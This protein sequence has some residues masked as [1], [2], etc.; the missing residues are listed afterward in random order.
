MTPS[1][2]H[3]THASVPTGFRPGDSP[4]T[5]GPPGRSLAGRVLV[6]AA[7]VLGLAATGMVQAEADPFYVSLLRDGVDAASRDDLPAAEKSLRLACFGFLE[8]LDL[9]SQCLVRLALVESRAGDVEGFRQTFRRVLEI[10]DRFGAYTKAPLPAE[11]RRSFEEQAAA[12]VPEALLR[13][14]VAFRPLVDD[15]LLTQLD[16]L[17]VGQQREALETRI[18]ADPTDTRWRLRLARLEL[19]QDRPQAALAALTGIDDGDG[20]QEAGCLK[21][22][23]R[24]LA[25]DCTA[26]DQAAAC[27]RPQAQPKLAGRLVECYMNQNRWAEADGFVRQ[28]DAA[29][30]GRREID[31]HRRRIEREL[32]KAR[33][34]AAAA[35]APGEATDGAPIAEDPASEAATANP[36]TPQPLPAEAAEKLQRARRLLG[37][38]RLAGELDEAFSLATE[39]ADAHPDSREAQFLA[40]EIAYR[41]SRWTEAAAYFRR[42]GDPGDE[43]PVLLFFKAVSL[44]ESGDRAGAAQALKRSLPLIQRSDYVDRYAEEILG[45]EG[46]AGDVKNR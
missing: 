25:G 14:S 46:A 18:A 15:K 45:E 2:R 22:E 21:H 43:Q 40:A 28:L 19:D 24:I 1:T 17:P 39:V 10:E 41:S 42:G 35:Q 30:A 16:S 12:H 23:A 31:R 11:L 26:V 44:Y 5:G 7:L 33:A 27:P 9:L 29:I 3:P 13:A 32:D 8:D 36:E 38:A 34:A 6:A 20:A 37:S 4:A